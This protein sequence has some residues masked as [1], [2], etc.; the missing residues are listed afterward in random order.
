MFRFDKLPLFLGTAIYALE[1]I[2]LALPV[3]TS[4]SYPKMAKRV[5]ISGSAIYVT[6]SG[7][8][9]AFGY[10]VG[11]GECDIITVFLP[12]KVY[13]YIIRIAISISLLAAHPLVLYPASEMLEQILFKSSNKRI[14]LKKR[15]LRMVLVLFTVTVGATLGQNGQNFSLFSS[16]VGALF[17]S[18]IGFFI[19]V[20]MYIKIFYYEMK[21]VDWIWNVFVLMFGLFIMLSGTYLSVSMLIEHAQQ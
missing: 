7:I 15:L 11:F 2:C 10:L 5:L 16:L 6:L 18:V 21:L 14:L 12:S 13:G 17:T 19:P 8:Y 20:I 3:E 4:M 1:G 9:G